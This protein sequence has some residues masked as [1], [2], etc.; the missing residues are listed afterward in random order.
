MSRSGIVIFLKIKVK[1]A[2]IAFAI[3]YFCKFYI[4]ENANPLVEL[5]MYFCMGLVIAFVIIPL[6]IMATA[7]TRR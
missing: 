7:R 5:L 2:G 3:D 4:M 6:F 1:M